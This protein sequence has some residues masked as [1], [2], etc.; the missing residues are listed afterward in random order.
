MSIGSA[1][2]FIGR[3]RAPRVQIEYDTEVYGATKRVE[4]PFVMAVMADLKGKAQEGETIPSIANRDFDEVEAGTLD[5][6]M[7]GVKPRVS[8]RVANKLDDTAGELPVDL[9]FTQMEDFS[10]IRIAEQVGPLKELLDARNQLNSLI[11]MMDGREDAEALIERVL[12]D[13][14][15]LEALKNASARAPAVKTD[16]T[17]EV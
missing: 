2:K 6:Y 8:F 4:L 12:G 9:T 13:N 1:Q 7:A 3:N 15:L 16:N 10:P 17:D 14:A 11:S 5:S